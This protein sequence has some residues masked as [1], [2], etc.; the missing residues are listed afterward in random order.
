MSDDSVERFLKRRHVGLL[1]SVVE[2]QRGETLL[3]S[4]AD[5]GGAQR[6]CCFDRASSD[7]YYDNQNQPVHRS[8]SWFVVM[9]RWMWQRCC[10]ALQ[11]VAIGIMP[12]GV[13]AQPPRKIVPAAVELVS[14]SPG[15]YRI[16]AQIE[17]AIAAANRRV[18]SGAILVDLK[19][20]ALNAPESTT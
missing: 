9:V 19:A 15:A 12:F 3:T 17:S 1:V 14:E 4:D 6:A 5:A 10:V 11:I 13:R 16:G 20:T 18:A 2:S 7:D 8:S